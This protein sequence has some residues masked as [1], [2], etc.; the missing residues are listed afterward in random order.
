TTL[1]TTPDDTDAERQT[2]REIARA[3]G[4][5]MGA[6]WCVAGGSEQL[7]F[8][9]GYHVPPHL[10]SSV[11]DTSVSMQDDVIKRLKR[12]E[13]PIYATNSQADHRFNHPLTRLIAHKS[14]V[15]QPLQGANE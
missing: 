14:L 4:A 1:A 8:V 11:A 10:R 3:L 15:L 5:D 2:T 13:G 9:A 7:G 12:T 6:V